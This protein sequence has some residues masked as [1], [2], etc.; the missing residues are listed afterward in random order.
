MLVMLLVTHAAESMM[1]DFTKGL[2]H[3]LR[4]S[5][6]PHIFSR[7]KNY[8]QEGLVGKLNVETQKDGILQVTAVVYGSE[9]YETSLS[10]NPDASFSGFECTCPYDDLCKHSAAVGLAFI[11]QYGKE[12][13]KDAPRVHDAVVVAGKTL[14]VSNDILAALGGTATPEQ[15]EVLLQKLQGGKKRRGT[16]IS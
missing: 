4:D 9:E 1:D 14:P 11:E 10:F 13:K 15:I 12:P 5:F 2:E 8:F 7:G 3:E 16:A 6:E